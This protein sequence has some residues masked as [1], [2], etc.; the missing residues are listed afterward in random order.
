MSSG[1]VLSSLGQ[2][3]DEISS[4]GENPLFHL[5]RLCLIF[6]Q[7]LFK[8]APEGSNFKWDE[9][10]ELTR[11]YITDETPINNEVIEK[12]PAI[13]STRS[14]FAWAGLGLDQLRNE[15]IRTGEQ[16]FTD[17]LS[18]HIT[19]N[20]MCRVAVE[21]EYLAWIVSRHIWIFRHLLMKLGFHKI[22]EG[23][24]ILGRT[25]AGALISGDTEGEIINVPVVVPVHFQWTEKVQEKDL[26]LMN[27]VETSL[28][29][30]MARRI[31]EPHS[32]PPLSGTAVRPRITDYKKGIINPPSIKGKL[33]EP[34][35]QLPGGQ[36]DPD[37]ITIKVIN[38]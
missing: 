1:S 2:S 3:G 31:S 22:G 35:E 34:T 16:V 12:R 4:W 9:D 8:N 19:F 29:A 28:L 36:P 18:G 32:K 23:Q 14:G 17:M 30:T 24:Q 27:S 10:D 33:I 5:T 26:P 7:E 37:G 25:P 38:N 15:R 6:L 11:L 21:S 20:C 13:A